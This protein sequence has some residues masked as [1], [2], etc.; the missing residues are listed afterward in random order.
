MPTIFE[1]QIREAVRGLGL[2]K[3]DFHRLDQFREHK[4][5]QDVKRHFLM[6]PETTCWWQSFRYESGCAEMDRAHTRLEELCPNEEKKVWCIC[7]GEEMVFDALPA[8]I[9]KVLD[10]CPVFE[11]AVVDKKLTWMILQNHRDVLYAIGAKT[12]ANLNR[13][14]NNE[15][16]TSA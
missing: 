10:V 1:Q 13:M 12:I 15:S 9:A 6:D 3:E 2:K 4:V 7:C 16:Y 5:L 11:Y 8:D 14:M